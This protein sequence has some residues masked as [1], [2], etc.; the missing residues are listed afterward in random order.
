PRQRVRQRRI[1]NPPR[2]QPHRRPHLLL[3]GHLL[4]RRQQQRRDRKSVVQGKS[5]QPGLA[6]NRKNKEPDHGHRRRDLQGQGHPGRRLRRTRRRHD[7][8]QALRQQ[9][10]LGRVRP[11]ALQLR[12]RQR[13]RQRRIRNPPRRQPHRRP[14]L[15]LGGHLLRRRQQQR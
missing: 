12:P 7:L 10:L 15:L 9:E 5:E 2:R 13:V 14:H 11:S 1:R 6:L 4:R 3:G 8:L